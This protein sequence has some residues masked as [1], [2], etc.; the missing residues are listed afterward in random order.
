MTNAQRFRA[1]Y[2][3]ILLR[4]VK[5]QPSRY[6]YREDRVP[7]IAEKAVKA[8]S[9]KTADIHAQTVR[10]TCKNLRIKHTY[11][12]IAEYLNTPGGEEF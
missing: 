2:E 10:E 12:A 3:R 11:K 5:E 1:E 4:N 9:E 8:L 6:V 7:E